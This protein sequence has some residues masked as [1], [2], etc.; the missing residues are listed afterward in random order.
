MAHGAQAFGD[1]LRRIGLRGSTTEEFRRQ[2]ALRAKCPGHVFLGAWKEG[3]LA[4]YLSIAEVE[5][6]AEIETACSADAF[7]RFTPND[8]LFFYALSHY[9]TERG[10]HVVTVGLSS[11]QPE[12]NKAGLH[13]FKAKVGLEAQ[14]VHRAFVLHPLLRPFATRLTLWSLNAALRFIP[15]ERHLKK[16]GGVLACVL[17]RDASP[18]SGKETG[19]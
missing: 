13:A 6:W 7:L 17:A 16:A 5:D 4:A 18:T 3:Q 12:S 15:R 9:L 8:A 1:T 2:V 10:C 19:Q 14:P 11:V